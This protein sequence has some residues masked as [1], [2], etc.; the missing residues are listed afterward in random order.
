MGLHKDVGETNMHEPKNMT[1]ATAGAADIGKVLVSKGDGT[2]ELRKLTPTEV[3]VSE[4][5][6][7]LTISNNS[8]PLAL[9]AATDSTLSTN[10]DYT[11]VTGIYDAIPHGLNNGITQQAA[12]LTVTLAGDYRVDV[13]A[14]TASTVN[15]T[16]VAFKFAVDGV[17]GLTRRPKNFMRNVGEIHNLA[18]FGFVSLTVGEVVTL[19]IASD[20]TAAITIEDLV[21]SMTLLRAT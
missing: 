20:K 15:S 2:S 3:G 21:F 18:A 19:H 8:T 5:Y 10:T 7:Q 12:S 4:H 13:W 14:D 11:L 1:T 16:T 9:T 17:I 6:G